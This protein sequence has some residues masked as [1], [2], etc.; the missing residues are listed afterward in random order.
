MQEIQFL[1]LLM[2]VKW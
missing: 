1:E 2:N